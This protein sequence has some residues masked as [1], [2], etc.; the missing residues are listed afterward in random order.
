VDGGR[1]VIRSPFPNRHILAAVG[2]LN[3]SYLFQAANLWHLSPN[4]D[5]ARVTLKAR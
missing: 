3:L 2:V 4:V 5:L 1:S